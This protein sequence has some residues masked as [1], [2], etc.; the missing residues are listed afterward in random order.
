MEDTRVWILRF[1]GLL[2]GKTPSIN[3]ALKKFVTQ[4]QRH[5]GRDVGI[6]AKRKWIYEPAKQR[7]PAPL[8]LSDTTPR[9][10]QSGLTGSRNESQ[11]G[12]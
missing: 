9:A 10:T 1:L 7:S 2:D 3:T 6:V 11:K 4:E 12:R 8:E 5:N